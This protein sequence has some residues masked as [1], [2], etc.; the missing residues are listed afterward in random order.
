[1]AS[2]RARVYLDNAATSWPKPQRVYAAVEHYLRDNGAAAGRG[3]Y[4]DAVEAG[5]LVADARRRAARWLG[6]GEARRVVF[7]LNGTD[8]LNLALH[9]LLA[10]G[11]GHVITTALEHNSVLRPLRKLETAGRISVSIVPPNASGLINEHDIAQAWTDE[12]RLVAIVH[13]SNVTGAVLPIGEIADLTRTR[14]AHV[15]V[16]AAQSAGHVPIDVR[17]LGI[18]LLAT[19]GH[20]GLLGP[21]GTGLLYVAPGLESTLDSVRQ[22]GTGTQSESDLQPETLPDKYEC[23]NLNVLGLAG[24]AAGLAELDEH[25]AEFREREA[26]LLERLLVGLQ[27]IAGVTVYGPAPGVPRVGVVSFNVAGYSPDEVAAALASGY[28]IQVRSGLHCAPLAHRA[29]GTDRAGGTVRASLGPYNE[30]EHIERLINAVTEIA[31][32]AL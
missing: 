20:K 12:T 10:R 27:S 1:M 6:A 14:G 4:S 24:L 7:G 29:L 26:S 31:H 15:L 28:G 17:A 3:V 11:G 16:D 21:L 22:G 9:G 2:D 13:A 32:S 30:P 19:S 25:H 5:A 18:D 23:G 8:A